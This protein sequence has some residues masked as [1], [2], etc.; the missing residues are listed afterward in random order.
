LTGM[1]TARALRGLSRIERSERPQ[2]G[3]GEAVGIGRGAEDIELEQAEDRPHGDALKT[4]GAAREPG[5][6]VRDLAENERH[7]QRHHQLGEIRA[8]Q[9]EKACREAEDRCGNRAY[10][11]PEERI[12]KPVFRQ[13]SG[14]ISANPEEGRVAQRH[15]AG[16]AED[17]IEGERE[18]TDDRDLVEDQ[19]PLRQEIQGR[20]GDQ[21]EEDLANFPSPSSDQGGSDVIGDI[22]RHGFGPCWISAHVRTAPAGAER[23]RRSS[24]CR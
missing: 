21:P 10:H 17:E 20:G 5:G 12:G 15:D 11:Q 4:I 22:R 23:E 14:G 7:A 9:H 24:A 19:M 2:E 3:H 18:Q 16:I 6:L 8:A 1:P 13:N